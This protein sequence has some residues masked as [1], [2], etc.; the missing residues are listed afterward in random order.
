MQHYEPVIKIVVFWVM[1]PQRR[2][3]YSSI[4]S[5]TTWQDKR[6]HKLEEHN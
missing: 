6:C 5:A 2:K 4:I 1:A 3:V